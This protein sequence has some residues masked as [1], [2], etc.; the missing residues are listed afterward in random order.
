MGRA[1][2]DDR[3]KR[4]GCS[5]IYKTRRIRRNPVSIFHPKSAPKVQ[6]T[7][8]IVPGNQYVS[9]SSHA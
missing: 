8:S 1:G 2:E 3:T 7:Y 6:S 5:F 4:V 9:T